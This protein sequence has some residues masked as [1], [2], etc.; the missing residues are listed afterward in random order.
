[1]GCGLALAGT[2]GVVALRPAPLGVTGQPRAICFTLDAIAAL[3]FQGVA[4]PADATPEE[5]SAVRMVNAQLSLMAETVRGLR[6]TD[7]GC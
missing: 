2:I 1:M 4:P 5:L 3:A 7:E 6:T